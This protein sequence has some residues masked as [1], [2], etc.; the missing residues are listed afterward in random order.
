MPPPLPKAKE[1]PASFSSPG[2]PSLPEQRWQRGATSAFACE[3]WGR[4]CLSLP[5]AGCWCWLPLTAHLQASGERHGLGRGFP[6]SPRDPDVSRCRG[7]LE[8]PPGVKRH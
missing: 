1:L 4:L 3:P 8:T 6:G 2:W 7:G 5:S